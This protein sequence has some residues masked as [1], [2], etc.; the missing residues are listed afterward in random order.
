MPETEILKKTIDVQHNG[1]T[2]TFRIPTYADELRIGIRE[3]NIRR[4]LDPGDSSGSAEGLDSTTYFMVR[5]AAV[6]EC[7]L[8]SATTKWPWTESGTGGAPVVDYTKWPT[9]K[10]GDAIAVG[11]G[12]NAEI[13]RFRE[14]GVRDT[15][16]NSQEVVASQPDTG[17]Q[18]V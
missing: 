6:F 7:L 8:E 5:T 13:A 4:N 14:G 17:G 10:V 9:D 15:N 12:Y 3:K 1:D 18:P 2:F 11:V 16:P